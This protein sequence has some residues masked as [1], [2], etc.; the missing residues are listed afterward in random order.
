MVARKWQSSRPKVSLSISLGTACPPLKVCR[1]A[2]SSRIKIPRALEV[3]G[4]WQRHIRVA[5]RGFGRVAKPWKR[6]MGS[7]KKKPVAC[8]HIE[9][10]LAVRDRH[11]WI[12]VERDRA[13]RLRELQGRIVHDVTPDQELIT[14]RRDAHHSVA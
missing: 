9:Y 2:N 1:R 11:S 10:F 7:G 4:V 8:N 12:M 3:L 13:V 6:Q 14:R 5:G